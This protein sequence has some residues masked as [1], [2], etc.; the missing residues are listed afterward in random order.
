VREQSHTEKYH[1]HGAAPCTTHLQDL[2][3][4]FLEDFQILLLESCWNRAGIVQQRGAW[5]K[6]DQWR[7]IHKK[8]HGLPANKR[9]KLFIFITGQNKGKS[10]RNIQLLKKT[11]ASTTADGGI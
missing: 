3:K 8:L 1:K 7:A 2:K 4:P 11:A 5:R 10:L 9:E 6:F